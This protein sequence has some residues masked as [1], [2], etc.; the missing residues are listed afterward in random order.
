[1]KALPA[2]RSVVHLLLTLAVV[3]SSLLSAFV[4]QPLAANHT[5][6]PTGAAVVGSLQSE[7]GCP[8]DWQPECANT[9]LVYAADDD[10]WQ[11]T[12]TV[13]T[14]SWEYKTALNNSWDEDYGAN[15]APGGNNI[16]LNLAAETAVK[17][18]YDHKSHWIT[19]NK[20]KIIAVAPGSFQ[21]ELGCAGDWLADCLRS[22]LQDTD[23]DGI[24]TF[25]TTALPAGSYEGKVAINESWDENYGAGGAPGGDNLAFTVTT[26]NEKVSFSYTASSHVLTIE[27]GEP[28]A[29]PLAYAVIRYHRPAKDYGNWDSSDFN[30]YWGLHLWGEAID[31][32]EATEWSAPKKFAGV[33]AY[34]AYVAVKLADPSKP[35]N[36][37]IHKG[38]TKDT[39]PDRTFVPNQFPT[40]WLVQGNSAN[41]ASRADAFKQ[42]VI[43]YNR[44]DATYDG[45]GCTCG[46]MAWPLA[47]PPSGPARAH[48]TAAMSMASSSPCP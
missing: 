4:P 8:G 2:R 12:F 29:E 1:M 15:A 40:N 44:P 46:A 34:G 36:F 45:W 26:D 7:L 48:P 9:D 5:P 22:W 11:A 17:F 33:D 39:D 28:V 19:D 6:V 43:H 25:V 18:Y 10:V 24:Y 23:G 31:P 38:N 42:T 41:H 13:P 32:A 37:I 3:L 27:V 20:T 14:G 35:I 47:L 30:D 16:A 21:S